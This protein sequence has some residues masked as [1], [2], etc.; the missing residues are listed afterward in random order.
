M[1]DTKIKEDIYPVIDEL[2]ETLAAANEQRISNILYHRMYKVSWTSRNELFVEIQRV[3]KDFLQ[4]VRG[5]FDNM[6]V[7]RIEETLKVID[8]L[9]TC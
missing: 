6:I 1:T 9:T 3:L 4:K 7:E 5:N 2:I 8:S